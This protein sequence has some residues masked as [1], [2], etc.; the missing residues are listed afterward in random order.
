MSDPENDSSPGVPEWVVTYGDMMPLLLTFFIMLVSL[1]ELKQDQGSIRAMMDAI[2]EA[3]GPTKDKIGT[4]DKSLQ[5]N[6]AMNQRSSSGVRSQGGIK[7]ANRRSE[8]TAGAHKTVQRINHGTVVTFGGPALFQ[9]YD[10]SLTDELKAKLDILY[11]VV[12]PKPNRVVVRGHASPAALPENPAFA[13]QLQESLKR[14]DP[15]VPFDRLDLSFV[16]AHTVAQYLIGKGIE[17]H[18][19]LVSAAGESKPRTPSRD[20]D[21]QGLNRRVDV[22]L[23]DSYITHPKTPNSR[24]R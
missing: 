16:R 24:K 21:G 6:S 18:R 8:G 5:T 22:F 4:P 11:N 19:I 3:F 9:S 23:I 17:R 10:A 7:K 2:R 20:K 12:A 13:G 15:L 14:P 1:S